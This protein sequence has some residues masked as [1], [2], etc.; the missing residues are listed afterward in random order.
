MPRSGTYAGVF[1]DDLVVSEILPCSE[2]FKS[3]GRDR[4]VME[5]AM[6]SYDQASLPVSYDEGVGFTGDKQK[7]GMGV[8]K[9]TAWGSEVDSRRGLVGTEPTKRALLLWICL[10][11]IRLGKASGSFLRRL[12]AGFVHPGHT[13]ENL[14][15][16]FTDFTSIDP[17]WASTI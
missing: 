1:Y 2:V 14:V 15:L 10:R 13:D 5:S 12:G 16:Y 4:D 8:L 11:V 9:F 6:R 3:E 17:S 7:P